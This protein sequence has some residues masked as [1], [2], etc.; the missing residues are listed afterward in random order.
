[1]VT[2][3]SHGTVTLNANGSFTYAPTAGFTGTDSFTY[4]ANDGTLKS[5]TPATV[6]LTIADYP[7]VANND[8]YTTGE[9]TVLNVLPTGVLANDTDADNDPLT[10]QL[11]SPTSHGNLTLNA[12]GSFTYTPAA[13]FSGTDSFTYNANDGTL[14][15]VTPATVTLTVTDHAPVANN[16]SYTTGENTVLQVLPTGVL[17]NDTDAD[18]DPLTANL[19]TPASHGNVT[20]NSNGSFTYTPAAGFTGTDS[21]TYQ[22]NDGT[23]NSAT[24]PP[25]T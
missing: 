3:A 6:T 14:N 12:N 22:A 4:N 8:S 23:L 18:G 21:F 2:N 1:M 17:S 25:S 11:V 19:V 13:G 20:L 10:A 24:P 9:N 16:D 15:S 5:V 7:P